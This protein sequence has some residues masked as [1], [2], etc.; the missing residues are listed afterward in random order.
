MIRGR[1]RVL[2]GLILCLLVV[3]PV[4]AD[5][6]VDGGSPPAVLSDGGELPRREDARPALRDA[7]GFPMASVNEPSA[8]GPV[9]VVAALLGRSATAVT[10][11]TAAI[12]LRLRAL[13]A[14]R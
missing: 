8:A 5:V 14:L 11:V 2:G 3:D 9:T 1:R 4:A 13:T 10:R 6:V 7:S 12:G